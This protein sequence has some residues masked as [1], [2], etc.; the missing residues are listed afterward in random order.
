MLLQLRGSVAALHGDDVLPE[1]C[2]IRHINGEVALDPAQ[3][4]YVIVND[5]QISGVTKLSQGHAS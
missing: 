1:H 2:V 5:K 3:D 4:A